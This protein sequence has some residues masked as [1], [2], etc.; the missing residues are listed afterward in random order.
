MLPVS[1]A[2]LCSA[3]IAAVPAVRWVESLCRACGMC[4]AVP[5]VCT[6]CCSLDVSSL[7][8]ALISPP[9]LRTLPSL[10]QPPPPPPVSV[11]SATDGRLLASGTTTEDGHVNI[12]LFLDSP[13]KL[14]VVAARE[15][16][17]S[18]SEDVSATHANSRSIIPLL[19]RTSR[20][21]IRSRINVCMVMGGGC[22]VMDAVPYDQLLCA[23]CWCVR[24]AGVCGVLMCAMC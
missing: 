16:F 9:F 2:L 3:Y 4:G 22:C 7:D 20:Q 5:F 19:F 13:S 15:G 6:T 8:R 24:R 12:G 17:A 11:L 1:L 14:R 21:F 23:V 18:C 10:L